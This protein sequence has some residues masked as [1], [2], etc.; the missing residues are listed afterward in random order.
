MAKNPTFNLKSGSESDLVTA[1][2]D[3][4]GKILTRS[5]FFRY[6]KL[7][8]RT[9]D[10]IKG[11]TEKIESN[12]LKRRRTESAPRKGSSSSS[13]SID[14]ELSGESFDDYLKSVWMS[15]W[16]AWTSDTNSPS[17][18]KGNSYAAGYF[19]TKC[20]TGNAG[21][22][23][24]NTDST[25][26]GDA[27]GLVT[28]NETYKAKYVVHELNPGTDKQKYSVL[29]KY[30]GETGEDLYQE[31]M[32][33]YMSSLQLTVAINAIVTGSF[34]VIGINHPKVYD[35]ANVELNLG[36][37]LASLGDYVYTAC[38]ASATAD[39]TTRY[40]SSKT[41]T[42]GA[43]LASGTS[44]S[45]YYTRAATTD[46]DKTAAGTAY[47]GSIPS[48]ACDTMQFTAREGF[49]YLN[50]TQIQF[51]NSLTFTLDNQLSQKYAIFESQPIS[52]TSPKLSISGDL[53]TYLVKDGSDK[54]YNAAVDNDTVE[55]LFCL[56][57]AL[58]DP[59]ALYLFQ[60]FNTKHTDDSI[61]GNGSDTYDVSLPWKS[62]NEQAARVL[63]IILPRAVD[64]EVQEVS[65]SVAGSP[66]VIAVLP[67]V[68]LNGTAQTGSDIT[69]T[70]TLDGVDCT[71]ALAIQAPTLVSD[72][73]SDNYGMVTA[74]FTP[75]A[76]TS[77]DQ[78]LGITATWNGKTYSKSFTV[79]R[80]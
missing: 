6:P 69:F 13:G 67:N 58:E 77:A 19:A 72:T 52:V 41:D 21:K 29:R 47:I 34:S 73:A 63:R 37:R 27:L 48:E 51:A 12:E 59:T 11:T 78:I 76:R 71:A 43:V 35:A 26:T 44:L 39:G 33:V 5:G 60:I 25:A 66:N 61:D 80:S 54:L 23:L 10:S 24:I 53:K 4:S 16:T 20:A 28:V 55:I 15:E 14:I 68:D 32:H 31:F 17:N 64:M 1:R 46:T 45:G 74:T 9:G 8:R 62:F 2:E 40:Y 56:Q 7:V 75:V 49:L 57:D 36:G 42:T 50:G 30:G 38:S 22:K 65:S 3:S 79:A 18:K 70:A